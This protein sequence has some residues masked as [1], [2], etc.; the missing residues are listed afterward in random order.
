MLAE[1][2][3]G[4]PHSSMRSSDPRAFPRRK[5]MAEVSFAER[6]VRRN[7]RG[8]GRRCVTS[9][10]AVHGRGRAIFEEESTSARAE[11]LIVL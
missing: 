9:Q 10:P 2:Q 5:A 1:A 4:E 11:G 6:G 8:G 3:A 7:P